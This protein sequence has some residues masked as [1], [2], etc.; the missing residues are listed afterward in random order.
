MIAQISLRY[1]C[2]L[3]I[4]VELSS[5]FCCITELEISNSNNKIQH[6]TRIILRYRI[7]CMP[8][9]LWSRGIVVFIV[10]VL[11]ARRSVFRIPAQITDFS[12]L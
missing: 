11:W 7:S 5:V 10:I 9:I 6:V 2:C 3:Q 12:F 4:L 8:N 1:S